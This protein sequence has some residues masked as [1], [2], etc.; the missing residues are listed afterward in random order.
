M[1]FV[2]QHDIGGQIIHKQGLIGSVATTIRCQ[3][4]PI[5]DA[6]GISINYE[7]WLIGGIQY[8]GI[9]RLLANTV[10]RK[11]LLAERASTNGKQFG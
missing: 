7:N 1:V 3:A 11:K 4:N 2:E 6:T 8:Y 9:G 10:D 5:D